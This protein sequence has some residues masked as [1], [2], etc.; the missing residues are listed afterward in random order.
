MT[1]DNM[2]PTPAMVAYYERRT[3]EHIERVRKNLHAI[4]DATDYADELRQRAAVHDASKFSDAERLPYIWLSEYHRCRRAEEPFAYPEG[5]KERVSAAIQHHV[6]NNRHHAE[7]HADP[8]HMTD[9]DLIEMVCDWTAMAQEF[10]END[11]STRVY[12]ERTVGTRLHLNDARRSF[13]FEMITLLD[14]RLAL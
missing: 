12:A 11:G 13:L 6:T 8:N 14:A 9:A 5:M 1:Q 7:F 10:G 2:Q 4:A 3:T